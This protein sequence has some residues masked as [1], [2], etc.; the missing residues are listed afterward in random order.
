MPFYFNIKINSN[1]SQILL[2]NIWREVRYSYYYFVV[3]VQ[4]LIRPQHAMEFVI[5]DDEEEAVTAKRLREHLKWGPSPPNKKQRTFDLQNW[6][7]TEK[8]A[9]PEEEEDTESQWEPHQDE[10][11]LE[12]QQG[13]SYYIH[14]FLVILETVRQCVPPPPYKNFFSLM[15]TPLPFYS[16][17]YRFHGHLFNGE[18]KKRLADFEALSEN[19]KR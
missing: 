9:G 18:E 12:N 8:R 2:E 15:F 6:V 13:P 5:S 4:R 17:V 19:A 10:G 3:N 7:K 16:I 1:H 11:L 14:N